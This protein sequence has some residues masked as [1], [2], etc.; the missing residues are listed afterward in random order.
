MS[1]TAIQD[2]FL[3]NGRF[4]VDI[5]KCPQSSPLT[6]SASVDPIRVKIDDVTSG[7]DFQQ[8]LYKPM[9][10]GFGEARFTF[11]VPASGQNQ[12]VA[13]WFK[14]CRTT[15]DGNRSSISIIINDRAGNEARRYN[16]LEC[17]PTYYSAGSY[18][19]DTSS[20]LCE[21][22]VNVGRIELA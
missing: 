7:T 9:W 17:F 6:V 16:L 12:D 22:H 10:T 3:E 18:S 2:Q 21:L 8:R 4:K 14:Q 13:D 5:Q 15:P 20:Q 11:R 1:S 19:T